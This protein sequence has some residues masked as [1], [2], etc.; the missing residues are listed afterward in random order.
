M[1][2]DIFSTLQHLFSAIFSILAIV[3]YLGWRWKRASDQADALTAERKAAMASF[4]ALKRDPN[5]LHLQSHLH[6]KYRTT[7]ETAPDAVTYRIRYIALMSEKYERLFVQ[8]G[9][10]ARYLVAY[11][12]RRDSPARIQAMLDL[13]SGACTD[14]EAAWMGWEG[15]IPV[16]Y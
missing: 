16:M 1:F 12:E 8:Q 13:R 14:A 3:A 2:G 15:M 5:F 10:Q 11:L 7:F 9:A 4:D 6:A